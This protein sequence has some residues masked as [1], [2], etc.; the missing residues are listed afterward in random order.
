MPHTAIFDIGKTNKK[1]FV[2][3]EDYH[4]VFE[5]NERL[6]ETADEDG[7]SCED[8]HLLADWVRSSLG[9]VLQLPDFQVKAVNFSA[10]GA[11][12]V[13]LDEQ[14]KILTPLYNYLKPY[15]ENLQKKFYE[16]YGG[17]GKLAS[18]TASP[19]L[20]SLNSGMQLY[21]LKQEQPAIFQQIKYAL[22]LPQFLGWLVS[23]QCFSDLTSIGCHTNLWHFEK[24][25]YH[26]WVRLE[27]IFE[28]LAPIQTSDIRNPKSKIG[29]GL[30]DSSA[31]LI[32]YLAC[33]SKP[34]VLLSTGTWNIAL[35]PFNDTPLTH[36]ELAQDCLCYLSWQGKPVKAS[37]LFA[38]HEH[39]QAAKRLG[40]GD[41]KKHGEEDEA[42]LVF[43][44]Q[45]VE[46]QVV[47][48]KLI[49]TGDVRKIFVD[50]GFSKNTIFMSLLAEAFPGMGIF[51]AEVAQASALGAAMAV[52]EYW[53]P[54][55]LPKNL[56][57][58]VRK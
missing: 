9:E 32:P 17:E 46:R 43:M 2:F 8:V 10:Y 3:D 27:G 24:N 37:R 48:I 6:P 4:I 5:K 7:D 38:G 53:N 42:Y 12:F 55:P 36:K 25:D 33:F 19:V 34:F 26:E 57:E 21:R 49:L 16:T 22:H 23:G 13:Y 56:I 51:A 52:H 30:H 50:G 14:G 45:L 11:S 1:L 35:N 28:K 54:N 44:K 41:L 39:D 18:E 58:T 20:G 47:A 15:P 29:T 40:L 31:A